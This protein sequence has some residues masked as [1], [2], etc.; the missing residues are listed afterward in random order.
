MG[1]ELESHVIESQESPLTLLSHKFNWSE[2]R[3]NDTSSFNAERRRLLQLGAAA[4]LTVGVAGLTACGGDAGTEDINGPDSDD[5]PEPSGNLA[6]A[7]FVHGVASGDPLTNAVILWTRLTPPKALEGQ[8]VNWQLRVATD[9]QFVTQVFNLAGQTSAGSDYTVK[10]DAPL[11]LSGTQY[12]Y[13]F[14]AG[15]FEASDNNSIIGR[16]RTAPEGSVSALRLGVCTCSDY[17]RGLYNAYGRLAARDDL[18]AVVHL[19]DY[20]YETDRNQVRQNMPPIDVV[21][22]AD[23]RARYASL[24]G[25]PN[26]QALHQAHPMIWVWDDHE[27]VDGTWMN[28]ADPN[29]H[30]PDIH[31][32]FSL[33]KEAARL[34]AFDWL[35][36]RVPDPIAN[37]ERIYRS[38]DFGDLIRLNMIDSRRIGREEQVANNI[39]GGSGFTLTGEFANPDRQMLGA[40]QEAW[41]IEQLTS[42]DKR[43]NLIGNQVVFSQI[44]LLGAPNA[45]GASI[46]ANND[47]WD[48]YDPARQRILDA[49]EDK[50]VENLVVLTGDVHLALAFEISR[51]PNNPLA[52]IPNTGIGSFGVE[53]VAPSISSAGDLQGLQLDPNELDDFA[54]ELVIRGFDILKVNNPHLQ[55]TDELNGYLVLDVTTDRINA[56]YWTVPTVAVPTNDES[57]GTTITI[58]SGVPAVSLSG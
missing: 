2:Q 29:D 9:S 27:T 41:L 31:G 53:L 12:F 21:T 18:Q 7:T 23:Y 50:P 48:G 16:T 4:S 15:N 54:E 3:M 57:L 45:T 22:L 32:P 33:R 25:D 14:S 26:L 43:W 51:D 11:P 34:A 37:P 8:P 35:P 20:M 47:Q 6:Q 42:S 58:N 44:K 30:D 40:A 55:Y 39:A 46:Y 52:Y 17:A 24:R 1:Y 19:G 56:E 28:G 5:S 13:Q 36:I 49:L 10:V 38:F